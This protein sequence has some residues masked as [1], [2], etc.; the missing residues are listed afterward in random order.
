MIR[1]ILVASI[2]LALTARGN[3]TAQTIVTL[4]VPLNLTQLSP[5]LEKIRVNCSLFMDGLT[6]TSS[7]PPM[8]TMQEVRVPGPQLTLTLKLHI[9]V[10]APLLQG[11]QGKPGKYA[12]NLDGYSTSLQ[13]WDQFLETHS[14]DA[15]RLKSS[16]GSLREILGTF[17]W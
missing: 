15:F 3:L 5:D 11:A 6:P 10:A 14:Q 2:A 13:K 8:V 16:G 1:K 7:Y 17:T 12:C 4:D 9:Y